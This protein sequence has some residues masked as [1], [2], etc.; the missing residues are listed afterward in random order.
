[1][2]YL[3]FLELIFWFIFF[4]VLD[5]YNL[6]FWNLLVYNY[7]K[8][9]IIKNI[10]FCDIV[11]LNIIILLISVRVVVFFCIVCVLGFSW[12]FSYVGECVR[13]VWGG[14]GWFLRIVGVRWIDDEG[15]D[16]CSSRVVVICK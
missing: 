8:K 5:N 10:E 15:R 9:I 2:V 1:M 13:W 16:I 11:D 4:N 14:V 7:K 3:S 12:K 6:I